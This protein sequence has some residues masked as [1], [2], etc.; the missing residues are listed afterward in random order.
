MA[1]TQIKDAKFNWVSSRLNISVMADKTKTITS[2]SINSKVVNSK[3]SQMHMMKIRNTSTK[4]VIS[5]RKENVQPSTKTVNR[6]KP[7]TS[8]LEGQ[9]PENNIVEKNVS[10]DSLPKKK[11]KLHLLE[12]QYASTNLI[13]SSGKENNLQNAQT[14][15]ILRTQVPKAATETDTY[16]CH[17]CPFVASKIITFRDHLRRVHRLYCPKCQIIFSGYH[18]HCKWCSFVSVERGWFKNHK[19]EFHQDKFSFECKTCSKVLKSKLSLV[20]HTNFVHLGI[21]YKCDKCPMSYSTENTLKKHILLDPHDN[22]DSECK[23][24][25][26]TFNSDQPQSKQRLRIH[27]VK[28]HEKPAHQCNLCSSIYFFKTDLNKPM[29]KHADNS[30]IH[31]CSLCDFKTLQKLAFNKHKR[32][33]HKYE[34]TFIGRKCSICDLRVDPNMYKDHYLTHLKSCSKCKVKNVSLLKHMLIHDGVK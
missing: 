33:S 16:Q 13:L 7:D 4:L 25:G 32:K 34:R 17:H 21:K 18:K 19:E 14:I 22:I 28:A 31:I 5:A 29:I 3:E 15:N 2:S 20:S 12:K 1:S 24:C 9:A 27:M 6:I 30:T 11:S 23:K 8:L 10:F 26:M